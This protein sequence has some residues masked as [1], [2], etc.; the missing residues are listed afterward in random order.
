[1][2]ADFFASS[3]LLA[4]A[5]RLANAG[6]ELTNACENAISVDFAIEAGMPLL[7]AATQLIAAKCLEYSLR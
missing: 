2:H 4:I 3:L 1:L 7:H 6:L 5:R